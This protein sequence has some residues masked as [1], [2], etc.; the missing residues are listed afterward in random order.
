MRAPDRTRISAD[1]GGRLYPVLPP[2]HRRAAAGGE[3]RAHHKR[4]QLRRFPDAA[5]AHPQSPQRPSFP[6]PPRRQPVKPVTVSTLREM[7]RRGE[8]IACLPAYDYSFA[9]LL[10]RAGVDM[11]MVGDSLG[12]VIQGHDTTLPVSVADMVYHSRCVARGVNRAR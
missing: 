12:M 4:R 9:S 3:R 10:D 1:P 11:I 7:K 6:E 8:K 2:L 5:V